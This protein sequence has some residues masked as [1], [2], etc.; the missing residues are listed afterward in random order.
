[1]VR[2][3][4]LI[5]WMNVSF[6][7]V[8]E[9]VNGFFDSIGT[10]SNYTK[11]GVLK[12]QGGSHYD[13]GSVTVRTPSERYQLIHFDSPT[14]NY[15]TCGNWDFYRG[16]FGHINGERFVKALKSIGASAAGHAFMIGIKV[17]A[18]MIGDVMAIMNKVQ[19]HMNMGNFDAC[20]AGRNAA[21]AAGSRLSVTHDLTC[22]YVGARKGDFP[23]WTGVST[24]NSPDARG[25]MIKSAKKDGSIDKDALIGDFNL[26]WLA[27][28]KHGYWGKASTEMKHFIM[29]LTGTYVAKDEKPYVYASLSSH[30]LLDVLLYGG[31]KVPVYVCND[32]ECLT[33]KSGT[34]SLKASDSILGK[35]DLTL[36]EIKKAIK[37]EEA[38]DLKKIE[39]FLSNTGHPVYRIMLAFMAATGSTNILDLNNFSEAIAVDLLS[40]YINGIYEGMLYALQQMKG[41]A[42]YNEEHIEKLRTDITRLKKD[43][44][45]KHHDVLKRSGI[46]TDLIGYAEMVEQKMASNFNFAR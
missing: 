45:N 28:N 26:A 40:R 13:G 46:N 9:N 39:A 10:K 4:L 3:V 27:I 6:A 11:A 15:D 44:R 23:D 18:P 21:V 31:N 8:K 25:Q 1:V 12:H 2:I 30:G 33:I 43:L 24:C 41:S 20:I 32:N 37:E 7:G 34:Y 38:A 16:G 22:K 35:V 14:I 17:V 42:T 5:V 36:S 19:N 29:S